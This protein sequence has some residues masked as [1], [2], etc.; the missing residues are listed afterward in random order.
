MAVVV[1]E[2]AVR[3]VPLD[4]DF[5]PCLNQFIPSLRCDV[6]SIDMMILIPIASHPCLLL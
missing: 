2:Q 5:T 4:F 1:V 6:A 3:P